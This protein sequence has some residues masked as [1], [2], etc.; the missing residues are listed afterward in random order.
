MWKRVGR[1]V[2]W[3]GF[4]VGVLMVA[5][6]VS[7]QKPDIPYDTL[8]ERYASPASRY[9]DLENG[10][11]VH[12][13]DEG[14]PNGPVIVLVHGFS[15]SLHAWEPWVGELG[16]DYRIISLDLPGHGLTEAPPNYQT[17]L[18]LYA[19][20]VDEV[21][22]RLGVSGQ[23]VI[24]GNSMGGGVAWTLA[25]AHPDRVRALVLVDAIG[26]SMG[27]G[28]SPLLSGLMSSPPGRA[29]VRHL[30]LTGIA[31]RGL[32]SAYVD[33]SLVTPALIGR[34]VDFSRAPGHRDILLRRRESGPAVTAATLA[35][36]RAPTLILHG[37]ADALIPLSSSQA[38]AKAIPG[39]RLVTYPGVGHVPMEQ[40]PAKSAA[41]L[42][43]F[44]E[45]LPALTLRPAT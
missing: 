28:G 42:R 5:A 12:Y 13:R 44:L 16:A 15:A 14:N 32:R 22:R 17:S 36:I 43:A 33:Q 39:A 1:I 9:M 35:T 8:R 23:Y 37:E 25:L 26:P 45:S 10:L 7:L 27:R 3:M 6:C 38:L 40:I 31:A 4:G 19:E 30:D 29:M 11:K 18:A 41:D 20:V 21:A 34:Y 2:L 24:A